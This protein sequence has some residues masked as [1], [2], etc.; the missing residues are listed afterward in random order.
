MS[1]TK[2]FLFLFLVL[3]FSVSASASVGVVLDDV[4]SPG[5][6]I[7]TNLEGDFL[8]SISREDLSFYDDRKLIPMVYDLAK[9]GETYFMYVVLP[10]EVRNYTLR[11]KD[12]HYFEGG[13][14]VRSTISQNF[15]V[16]GNVTGFSVSPGLMITSGD[17]SIKLRNLGSSLEVASSFEGVGDNYNLGAGKTTEVKLSTQHISESGLYSLSFSG[18][19]LAYKIPVMVLKEGSPGFDNE[20][21]HSDSNVPFV[22][23]PNE[24]SIDLLKG[25]S[26]S[27]NISIENSADYM[28][29]EILFSYSDDLSG[30]IEVTPAR[31]TNITPLSVMSTT[32]V[33]RVP[34]RED[35]F[36]GSLTAFSSNYSDSSLVLIRSL[37]EAPAPPQGGS[38][39][40]V[41]QS[42]VSLG[43]ILCYADEVCSSSSVSSAEGSCCLGQCILD[44]S[45]GGTSKIVVTIII[46]LVLVILFFLYRKYKKSGKGEGADN[47]IKSLTESFDSSYTP[48]SPA[49]K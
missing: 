21:L 35:L 25:S 36:E 22:L 34:N 38:N 18:D 15:S 9:L 42:C 2:Y 3:F 5:Q 1:S 10:L 33:I 37:S 12:A 23:R 24:L 20:T 29:D 48:G 47:K 17:F 27:L 16:V 8:S 32:L 41:S 39:M 28:L 19:G 7:I 26:T 4:Y 40:I 44:E 30:I 43:G 11:I 14:E 31:L 49:K 13:V 45:S 46:I 6:T